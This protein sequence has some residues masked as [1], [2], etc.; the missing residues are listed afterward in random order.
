MSEQNRALIR[1]WFEEVWNKGNVEAIDEMFAANG[2]SHD[3]VDEKGKPIRGIEDFKEIHKRYSSALSEIDVRVE[4]A[5]AEGDKVAV[6]C[7]VRARHSG[8]GLGVAATGKPVEYTGMSIV[9]IRDG[10]I[11][12]AWNNWDFM[13][14]FQQVGALVKPGA[15]R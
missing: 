11:V 3:F 15:P 14:L 8:E 2:V 10:K 4:D 12:D 7:S 1:R 9:R 6:R 5:I 13:S